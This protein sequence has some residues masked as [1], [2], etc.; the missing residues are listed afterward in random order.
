ML[1]SRLPVNAADVDFSRSLFDFL[2]VVFVCLCTGCTGLTAGPLIRF[3]QQFGN[4]LHRFTRQDRPMVTLDGG[5]LNLLG[6][7]L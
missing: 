4:V 2:F 7:E 6:A 1:L 3:Q 5:H